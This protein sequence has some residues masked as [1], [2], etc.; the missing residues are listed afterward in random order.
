MIEILCQWLIGGTWLEV[1]RVTDT[2]WIHKNEK[3]S[4]DYWTQNSRRFGNR[5]WT[6]KQ[7]R[8]SKG[9]KSTTV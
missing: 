8:S 1:V 3:L 6:P 9:R 7:A 2:I 4:S 5:W